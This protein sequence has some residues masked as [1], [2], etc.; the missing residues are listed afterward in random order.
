[1]L[2]TDITH[3]APGTKHQAPSTRHQT[4]GTGHQA[5]STEHPAPHTTSPVLQGGPGGAGSGGCAPPLRGWGGAPARGSGWALVARPS[6]A[7][8]SAALHAEVGMDRFPFGGGSSALLRWQRG[9]PSPS[10]EALGSR[11]VG[12]GGGPHQPGHAAGDEPARAFGCTGHR[13]RESVY[14]FS[15]RL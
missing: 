12:G 4:S 7:P 10:C 15:C 9:R 1:M 6:C 8:A 11:Q 14:A 2:F 13:W 3:Q 5:P